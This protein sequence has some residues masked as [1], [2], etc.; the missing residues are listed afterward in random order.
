VALGGAPPDYGRTAQ[1]PSLYGLLRRTRHRAPP[2][3]SATL[4]MQ[5]PTLSIR[6]PT[7]LIVAKRVGRVQR[8]IRR[9]LIVAGKPLTTTE[10]ARSIYPRPTKPWHCYSVRRTAPKFAVEYG[11]RRSAGAPIVWKL[12]NP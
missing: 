3:P 12:K 10:L 11:R 1:A 6:R 8:Q 7:T 5:P 4:V 2:L 9:L